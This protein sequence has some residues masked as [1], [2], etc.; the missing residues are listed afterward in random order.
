MKFAIECGK[1]SDKR[2]TPIRINPIGV[3]EKKIIL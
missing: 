1:D 3:S 2:K